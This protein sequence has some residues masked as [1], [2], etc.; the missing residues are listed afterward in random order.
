MQKLNSQSM[1]PAFFKSPIEFR[2]WLKKNHQK[3]TELIVG[4]Y[5]VGSGKKSMTW[6][7][8]VDEAICF[9]WIDGIRRTIDEESYSIRFT[10]RKPS[11]TWSTINIKKVEALKKRKL[12][13]PAGLVAFERRKENRSGIYSYENAPPKLD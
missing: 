11:S 8:S 4:Y 2:K 9:G 13:H 6:S 12:M 10:P 3:K 5:K 7:E 1:Q